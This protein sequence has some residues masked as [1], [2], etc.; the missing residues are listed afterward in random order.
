MLIRGKKNENYQTFL[1]IKGKQYTK[2]SFIESI[3]NH[4]SFSVGGYNPDFDFD[5][6]KIGAGDFYG[7]DRNTKLNMCGIRSKN[8]TPQQVQAAGLITT[9]SFNQTN[10]KGSLPMNKYIAKDF[11]KICD[12]IMSLGWFNLY[13]G[14]CF[15][16]TNS[17]SGGISRHCWGIAVDINPGNAG[18]PWFADSSGGNLHIPKNMPEPKYGSTP[19]K[20]KKCP[21]HGG[22]DR[23]RC[24]WH[25]G[26]PVVQIFLRHGWGWGGA[27]GDVMHFSIDDGH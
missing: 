1:D 15:R 6:S 12:E 3:I 20:M 24:I 21:Y 16:S 4:T 9:V 27:Y 14:N 22:Y 26:H 11:Q 17:V 18:N 25:W 23:I 5:I 19:W 13:V 7:K 2:E 10:G 8:M